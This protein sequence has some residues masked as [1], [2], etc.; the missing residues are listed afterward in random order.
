MTLPRE[1]KRLKNFEPRTWQKDLYD[2]LMEEPDD[3]TVTWIVDKIG[4][5]GKSLFC[6]W[7][8]WKH[9]DV[10]SCTM[11]KSADILTL[12]EEKYKTYLIDLPRSYD[13]KYCPFNAIEQ[14]KNGYVTE[15]KL[16]KTARK[17]FF[18]PPHIVI[19]SNELPDLN[20][21]SNDRWN[22]IEI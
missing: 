21:L 8:S 1:D 4:G 11:N 6:K 16:K 12:V 10:L 20:K 3:R 5:K 17:L 19:F 22:I 13:V 9:D 7:I 14:I 18:A 15:G 2:T